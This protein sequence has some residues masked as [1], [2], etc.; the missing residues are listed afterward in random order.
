DSAKGARVGRLDF[1]CATALLPRGSVS[2]NGSHSRGSLTPSS[3][4]AK[5][6]HR[7]ATP[8]ATIRHGWLCRRT[9]S[10]PTFVQRTTSAAAAPTATTI[11]GART[12]TR[13]HQLTKAV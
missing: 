1:R 4:S 10:H 8:T 6:R 2:F 12:A 5:R 3:E 7:A 9:D 11:T 13:A